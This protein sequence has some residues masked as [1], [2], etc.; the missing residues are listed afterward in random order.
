MHAWSEV[1][2]FKDGSKWWPPKSDVVC[3]WIKLYLPMNNEFQFSKQ[4]ALGVSNTH[5]LTIRLVGHWQKKG[6]VPGRKR[7]PGHFFYACNGSRLG[8]SSVIRFSAR[9]LSSTFK[10][11]SVISIEKPW[12]MR[13]QCTLF[14]IWQEYSLCHVESCF[15]FVLLQPNNDNAMSGKVVLIEDSDCD[16]YIAIGEVMAPDYTPERVGDFRR[17]PGQ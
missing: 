8:N 1:L 10:L 3:C 5:P 12:Y 17:W 15:I 11:A 16:S 6:P 9:V 13:G 7:W 14:Y 2:D 4:Y